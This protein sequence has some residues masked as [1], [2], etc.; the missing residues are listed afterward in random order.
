V[1]LVDAQGV[2]ATPPEEKVL[3]G[4]TRSSILELARS[5]GITTQ[6]RRILPDEL[7]SAAE[8]FLT[9][10][11]AGVW[12]VESVDGH[13]DRGRRARSGERAAR[14]ALPRRHARRGSR[15]SRTGSRR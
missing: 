12:P 10:T 14:E 7:A 11:T 15:R 5:E 3:H 9:G 1:F 6:E 2:L 4:V 13:E 8:V